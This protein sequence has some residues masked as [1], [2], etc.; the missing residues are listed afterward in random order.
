MHLWLEGSIAVQQIL[1]IISVWYRLTT[2]AVNM[3]GFVK[4]HLP[5]QAPSLMTILSKAVSHE[6]V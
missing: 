1:H 6:D 2:D 3:K 4:K 5:R